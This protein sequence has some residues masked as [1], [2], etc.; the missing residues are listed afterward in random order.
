[1]NTSTKIAFAEIDIILNLLDVEYSNKI[2][3]ELKYTFN[4]QKDI[5]YQKEIDVKR[6]LAEQ[7]LTKETLAILALLRYEYWC[8]SEEEKEQLLKQYCENDIKEDIE[9]KRK[10]NPNNLFKE[11]KERLEK[12]VEET[13][14]EQALAEK[15]NESFFSKLLIKI[16]SIFKK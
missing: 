6:P 1:M 14:K 12:I 16:K 2:P 9:Y 15:N 3:G 8:N 13:K 11:E 5:N 7:N 4:T 10:Y